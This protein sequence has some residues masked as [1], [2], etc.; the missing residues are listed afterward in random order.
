[1]RPLLLALILTS[2]AFS[3]SSKADQAAEASAKANEQAATSHR[4]ADDKATEAEQ[5]RGEATAAAA[6]T[7]AAAE[8]A[9][10]ETQREVAEDLQADFDAADRRFIA[11]QQEALKATPAKK[12]RADAAAAEVTRLEAAVMA[13]IARLRAATGAAWDTTRTQVEADTAALD[14]AID[15]LETALR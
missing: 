5:A 15:A 4:E 9:T 10:R 3:C 13:S 6:T 12:K 14:R 1:M 2:T 8:A 7:A 11:L